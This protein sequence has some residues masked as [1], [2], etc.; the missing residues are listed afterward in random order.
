M[1]FLGCFINSV[2]SNNRKK[3]I[4]KGLGEPLNLI[5]LGWLLQPFPPATITSAVPRAGLWVH[6]PLLTLEQLCREP[7]SGWSCSSEVINLMPISWP[8]SPRHSHSNISSRHG[9][10]EALRTLVAVSAAVL[11]VQSLPTTV[12][13]RT[14][15]GFFP[16]GISSEVELGKPASLSFPRVM[17]LE[18]RRLLRYCAWCKEIFSPS[19]LDLLKHAWQDSRDS[20]LC[21]EMDGL[22]GRRS[23]NA[24]GQVWQNNAKAW[25][26]QKR[27]N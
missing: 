20:F 26:W 8:T 7:G 24:D 6:F 22:R 3:R 5:P 15:E 18:A 19:M 21:S 9:L 17:S 11:F 13:M 10:R 14:T 16:L 23:D 2:T 1:V 27:F 12:L 25:A 4:P